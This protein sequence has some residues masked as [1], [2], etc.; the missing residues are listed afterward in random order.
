VSV[1]IDGRMLRPPEPLE[2]TLRALETL[3]D[4]GELILLVGCHPEPLLFILEDSGYGWS[5]TVHPDG[6]HEL[7]I[8]KA[9]DG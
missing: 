9:A 4:E 3:P 5:E 2:Q 7:V 6:T 1:L 8:R